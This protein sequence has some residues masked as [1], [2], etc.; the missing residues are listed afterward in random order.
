VTD[1]LECC[2]SSGQ[3]DRVE[4][5]FLWNLPIGKRIEC[6]LTLLLRKGPPEISFAF[7]C[8][9]RECGEESEVEISVQEIEALQAQA[10][11]TEPVLVPLEN[12]S[13]VLRRPTGSDQLTWLQSRFVDKE[14]AIKGML[15]TLVL[16]S[17]AGTSVNGD[18]IPGALIPLVER[19]MEEFDPL[20][21]FSLR[22]KCV[23][24]GAENLL[25]IDL[26]ELSLRQLQ[27]AQMRL[28]ASVHK[29]AAHYHWSEQQIFSVPYWR[30]AR[31]LSLVEKEKNQ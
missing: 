18:A 11:E 16:E 13:L 24:C 27:Q 1:I 12:G 4:Q 7:R 20:V 3:T 31:Y 9:E 5:S 15:R 19:T 2:T 23:A 6:L 17:P 28:L 22:V 29:L 14:A 30:R 21:N 26:E 8:P 10:Y 25:E